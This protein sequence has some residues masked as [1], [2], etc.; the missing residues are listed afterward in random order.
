MMPSQIEVTPV[1]RVRGLPVLGNLLEFR[2]DRSRLAVR[3]AREFGDIARLRLG[4]IP[5]TM[6]SSPDLVK[7]LLVDKEDAFIK[8]PGLSYFARP[9][10]GNGLLTSEQGFH[11][12]QRRMIA[13]MFIHKRIGAYGQTMVERGEKIAARWRDGERL[14]VASEMMSLTLEIV[15]KTLFDAE[16]GAEAVEIGE[17]LTAAME[18]IIESLNSLVPIPRSWPTPRNRRNARAVARLDETIYRMIRERRASG[19][20]R[21]DLLSMLLLARD[22]ESADAKGMDDRQVRDEAMTL[23]LAGHET[24]ANA[25]AWTWYLLARHPHA[26]ARLLREVDEVLG[27]RAPTIE[28]L[29]RLPYTLQV[30]KEA[31]RLYPPAYVL[32]RM[33]RREVTL[34]GHSIPRNGIVIVSVI[35]MQRRASWFPD[36]DAFDPERFSTENEKKIPRYAYLP[37]GAGPRVCIG[38][39]FAMMEGQLLV[40]TIAQRARFELAPG[41]RVEPEPLVTLRPRGGMPMRVRRRGVQS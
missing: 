9:L 16:V 15:G 14:D 35:G 1:P 39:H 31:M 11:R 27:G 33:A 2:E 18:H 21:G 7:E 36:P 29:P 41:V 12:T 10:L 28:D 34:G 13:P 26:Y 3:V 19:E 23:F 4:L 32:G 25:L 5:V 40:A 38:N 24:T 17:A 6:I 37:F 20:D 8:A 30:F 22:D